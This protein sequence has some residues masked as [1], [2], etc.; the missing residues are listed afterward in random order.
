MLNKKDLLLYLCTDQVLTLG[1]PITQ[2]LEE[3]LAGGVTMVQVREKDAS[4]QRFY[5][6]AC[7]VQSL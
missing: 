3:A 4:T 5:E 7:A 1:R 2:A 6:V